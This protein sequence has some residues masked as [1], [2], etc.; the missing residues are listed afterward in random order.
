MLGSGS[1]STNMKLPKINV[2][3]PCTGG[4]GTKAVNHISGSEVAK[5]CR[6]GSRLRSPA[7]VLKNGLRNQD[8]KT[9][10]RANDALGYHN[11]IVALTEKIL[12]VML[13]TKVHEI[14]VRGYDKQHEE[15]FEANDDPM[16]NESRNNAID[17]MMKYAETPNSKNRMEMEDALSEYH[18]AAE[19]RFL[20]LVEQGRIRR[21]FPWERHFQA[22]CSAFTAMRKFDGMSPEER[23]ILAEKIDAEAAEA[24]ARSA[25][26][27]ERESEQDSG[28]DVDPASFQ[29]DDETTQLG[30]SLIQQELRA[31]LEKQQ[32]EE[33]EANKGKPQPTLILPND[34]SS[35]PRPRLI[36]P[37]DTPD[38]WDGL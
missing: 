16:F 11:A 3:V 24:S 34:E 9:R 31:K 12:N 7:L 2:P 17:V 6:K 15:F 29:F 18:E 38:Q 20:R 25:K 8:I 1:K 27:K 32:R 28:T 21:D 22:D 35:K 33:Q 37:D 14:K 23:A 5:A 30:L 26:E 36:L 4:C 13:K 10:T 19:L